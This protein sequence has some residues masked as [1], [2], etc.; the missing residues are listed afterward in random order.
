MK[1]FICLDEAGG[2]SFNKRRQSSD[3]VIREDMLQMIGSQILLVNSY[4]AK[5]FTEEESSRI[6]IDDNCLEN[7]DKNTFVF[8]ENTGVSHYIS[9]VEQIVIYR[10]QRKYPADFFFDV[11]LTSSDWELITQE[12]IK[13][14]SHECILKQV[15]KRKQQNKV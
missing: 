14:Y 10:W 2:M 15:Y 12:E 4:T 9:N 13:G 1:L 8:L 7:A 6:Q 11:D 3:R 5:Q